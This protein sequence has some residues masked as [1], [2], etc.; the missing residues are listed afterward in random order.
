MDCSWIG[1]QQGEISSIVNLPGQ[2]SALNQSSVYALVVSSFHLR[3]GWG[4]GGGPLPKKQLR[5]VCQAF[6]YIFQETGGL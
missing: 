4:G 3:A 2:P 6:I 5:D 1:W